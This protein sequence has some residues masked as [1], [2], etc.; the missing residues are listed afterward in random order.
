MDRIIIS[1][2]PAKFGIYLK[3]TKSKRSRRRGK[4]ENTQ[5]HKHKDYPTKYKERNAFV[6]YWS[7]SAVTV[8]LIDQ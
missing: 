2:I 3:K 4:R 1:V 5:T 7:T 6:S 8:Y